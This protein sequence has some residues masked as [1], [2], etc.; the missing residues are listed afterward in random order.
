MKLDPKHCE[1]V[2]CRQMFKPRIGT[3]RFCSV[4]CKARA[5]S[6]VYMGN[7]A[8]NEARRQLAIQR[9]EKLLEEFGP[10]SERDVKL[11]NRGLTLGYQRGYGHRVRH[12]AAA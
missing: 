11:F 5:Q 12:G 3:Q 8:A 6:I 7:A 2:T 9:R 10:L 4:R 1:H